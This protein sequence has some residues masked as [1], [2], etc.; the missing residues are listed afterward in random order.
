MET[1]P[2][3]RSRWAS[4]S[5][6]V[7]SANCAE[8]QVSSRIS[9]E[10]TTSRQVE[11][12]S[13]PARNTLNQAAGFGVVIVVIRPSKPLDC[14]RIGLSYTS[15]FMKCD[16]NA[17]HRLITPGLRDVF[18]GDCLTKAAD[19]LLWIALGA[20]AC[21]ASTPNFNECIAIAAGD[22]ASIPE[23][24]ALMV[25]AISVDA[26]N[27]VGSRG[28]ILVKRTLE[29]AKTF[30]VIASHASSV[31]EANTQI[32]LPSRISGNRALAIPRHSSAYIGTDDARRRWNQ[33][34]R[35]PTRRRL[36][37]GLPNR[38]FRP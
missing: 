8:E 35:L 25:S 28:V 36:A 32:N 22:C 18:A 11:F 15:P 16:A 5:L 30:H 17:E 7:L 10:G 29:P 1:N 27:I 31:A 19:R 21:V 26:G 20:D 3:G 2:P 9:G 23:H 14:L 12:R 4:F 6:A 13:P 37:T 34:G 33:L 24:C 38:R